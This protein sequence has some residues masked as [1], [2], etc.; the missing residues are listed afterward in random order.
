MNIYERLTQDHDTQRDIARQL[1]ET[2]GDSPERRTLFEKFAQEMESHANAEEQVF[3]A[4]LLAKPEVQPKTRHGAHEHQEAADLLEELRETD[5][6]SSAWLRRFE[7]LKEALE[8]HMEEEEGELFAMA[9]QA[10][11]ADE[12]RAMPQRFDE[13][14]RSEAS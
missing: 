5:M 2:E 4:S 12:A 10:L 13:R 8:H 6:S 14:K 11:S 9:R 1:M 3:Y 7:K